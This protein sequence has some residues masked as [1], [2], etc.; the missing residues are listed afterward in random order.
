MNLNGNTILIT[1]GSEGVGFALARAL[2]AN[3]RVI[4]CGRSEEKLRRAQSEVPGV[5]TRVCDITDGGQ[6]RELLAALERDVPELNLLINN[7]GGGHP[8]DPLNPADTEAALEA[9]MALNFVAPVE[10]TTGLLPRLRAQSRAGIVNITTGLVYLP[11]AELT[12]YCAAKAALHS[13]SRSLRWAL[14]G[15][16][17]EVCEVLLPLVDTNFHRGRLPRNIPAISAE[18]AARV[19]LKGMA[20]GESELRPGKSALARWLDFLA[21]RRGLAVVNG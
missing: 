9:D 14:R 8:V 21:P 10:L 20:R 13:Y 11:K 5:H 2:V 7:A 6:R 1:G 15:A 16:P 19:V 18:Q 4:V 3:N 12:F 17:V